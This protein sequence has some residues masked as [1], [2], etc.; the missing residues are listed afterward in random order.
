MYEIEHDVPLPLKPY[1][2]RAGRIFTLSHKIN[3]NALKPGDS[4]FI[5]LAS[6]PPGVGGYQ[7]GQMIEARR[8]RRPREQYAY[9]AA[10]KNGVVGWRLWLVSRAS[11]KPEVVHELVEESPSGVVVCSCGWTGIGMY[12]HAPLIKNLVSD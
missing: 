3:W 5:P 8:K 9:R 4:V 10:T 6:L 11:N 1:A 7:M 12:T 2:A